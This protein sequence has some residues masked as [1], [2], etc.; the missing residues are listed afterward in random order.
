MIEIGLCTCQTV[1]RLEVSGR[2]DC[3]QN[4]REQNFWW[5]IKVALLKGKS[6]PTP[7][8]IACCARRHRGAC[9]GGKG[10]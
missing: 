2:W 3:G 5:G 6:D 9:V 4:R 10:P 7:P 1:A 8:H